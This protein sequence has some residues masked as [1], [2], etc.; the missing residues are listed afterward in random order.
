MSAE[1][2]F[3]E[4]LAKAQRDRAEAAHAI[5]DADV[6]AAMDPNGATMKLRAIV[7]HLKDKT[8]YSEYALGSNVQNVLTRMRRAG[9]VELVKGP[10][11]GWR[12]CGIP[13]PR[14]GAVTR[15]SATA[16]EICT[17]C[18]GPIDEN[19]ECR[20]E[21]CRTCLGVGS[22]RD[23]ETRELRKCLDCNGAGMH[24]TGPGKPG[25]GHRA[26]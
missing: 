21:E 18:Q 13:R 11:S 24:I 10:G 19:G 14:I 26:K 25:L 6:I 12:I 15:G 5:T 4:R 1:L 7:A 23:G 16:P 8:G 17:V 22:I 2:T 3:E 20:C 9:R